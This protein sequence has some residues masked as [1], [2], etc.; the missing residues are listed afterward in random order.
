MVS[1]RRLESFL[2]SEVVDDKS[3]GLEADPSELSSL[4]HDSEDSNGSMGGVLVRLPNAEPEIVL[5]QA[6]FQWDPSAL[7]PTLLNIN[8]HIKQGELVAVVGT[9]GSGKSSI[10]SAMLGEMVMMHGEARLCG[11]VAYAPQQAWI[12]NA[13]VRE[14]I[15]FGLE[16]DEE[17]YRQAIMVS[18]LQKDIDHQFDAGDATE[19]G[20]RALTL[21]TVVFLLCSS[22]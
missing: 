12:F 6:T 11:T 20:T 14:N 18:N 22:S 7:S 5:R 8:L 19:I 15:L 9:T 13:T 17:M 16:Y 4:L 3:L 1:V 21:R 2:L 10:V